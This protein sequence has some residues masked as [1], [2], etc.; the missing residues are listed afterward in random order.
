MIIKNRKTD[1]YEI[2]NPKSVHYYSDFIKLNYGL[3]FQNHNISY[4]NIIKS[5]IKELY[6][7]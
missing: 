5:K 3:S 7:T 1:K 6:C 4:I 2:L